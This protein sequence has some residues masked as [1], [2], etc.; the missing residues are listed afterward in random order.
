MYG[1][2]VAWLKLSGM[3]CSVIPRAVNG[4]LG[5]C[6]FVLWSSRTYESRYKAP[7][8]NELCHWFINM[9]KAPR[10][11]KPCHLLIHRYK[12]RSFADLVH[13]VWGPSDIQVEQVWT[14]RGECIVRSNAS[15]VMVVG[16][17]PGSSP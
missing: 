9:Y 3:D 8:E 15:R 10:V 14:C 6:R 16:E 2:I 1:V 7:R 11:D 13:V 17:P 5:E 4:E 12:T